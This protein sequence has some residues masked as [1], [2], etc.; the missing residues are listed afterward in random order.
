MLLVT[1][2][3]T[4][5]QEAPQA[6]APKLGKTQ[7]CVRSNGHTEGGR[8]KVIGTGSSRSDMCRCPAGTR[9]IDVSICSVG[10][11]APSEDSA[12]RAWRAET[13]KSGTLVGAE[14]QGKPVCVRRH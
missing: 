5:A 3:V 12:F 6:P 10:M 13:A 4:F 8:C 11:K 14:Y 1:G 2:S 7:I 9:L